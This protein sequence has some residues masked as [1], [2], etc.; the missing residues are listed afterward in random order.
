MTIRL[1]L[2]DDEDLIRGALAALLGLEDDL[3]VV[4]EAASAA[5]AVAVACAERPDLAVLDLEMPPGDGLGAA[6]EIHARLGVPVVLVTRHARPGVLRRAL[7][8]GVRGFVPKTTPAARLA[9]IIREVHGGR[10]YV[11]PDIAAAAL[12]ERPCPLT[13]RELD[14]VRAAARGAPVAEI[15]AAV[16]LA[17]GTVRNYL[18][19]AMAKLGAPN[20]Q[21]A[22]RTAWEQGWI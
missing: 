5:E 18:S 19:A 17:P 9:A 11:D 8:A 13:P 22:A 10:R 14:V 6:A 20:R 15:A 3:V 1:V 16:H 4:G 12:T 2:A 21:A 7:A